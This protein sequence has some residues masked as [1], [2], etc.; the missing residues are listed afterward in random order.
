[1]DPDQLRARGVTQAQ[2]ADAITK[3]NGSTGGSYIVQNDQDYMV[4]GLGLL[5]TVDDIKN[6]VISTTADGTPIRVSDVALVEIGPAV[7]LGQVGKN[8]DDDTVEGIVLMRRGE[9]P[10]IAVE[11]IMAAWPD[12]VGSLPEGMHLVPLYD[13]TKLAK[14]TMG[15]IGQNVAMGIFLVV[16]ILML[17]LFQV[18]SALICGTVI[19][20]ALL[21]AFALLNFFHVP[22]NLL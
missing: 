12:L 8:E 4:R 9:N 6:V 18:R 10:S 20:L 14:E 16:S 17:C 13:R 21:T 22:A 5:S 2:V 3:S 19:P 1:I 15:T 11:N 7:R